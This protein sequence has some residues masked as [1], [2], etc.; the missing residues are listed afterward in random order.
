MEP[1]SRPDQYP[2]GYHAKT[3]GANGWPRVALPCPAR[4]CQLQASSTS[5]CSK[6]HRTDRPEISGPGFVRLVH[7]LATCVS[8]DTTANMADPSSLPKTNCRSLSGQPRLRGRRL[9]VKKSFDRPD[10]GCPAGTS[11]RSGQGN[12]LWADRHA[13]LSIAAHLNPSLGSE[14]V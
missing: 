4:S 13:V 7:A 1:T 10:R 14:G 2:E 5:R 11:D 6:L 3:H 9:A 8:L 12:T